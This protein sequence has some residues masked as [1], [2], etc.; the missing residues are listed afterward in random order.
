[1]TPRTRSVGGGLMML[2]II[3]V[4]IGL[5][6]CMEVPIGNP[7]RSRIDPELSGLWTLQDSEGDM[8]GIVLLEPYDK[9]TWLGIMVEPY[10]DAS[11]ASADAEIDTY[12]GLVAASKDPSSGLSAVSADQVGLYKIWLTKLGGALFMV[13]Q[14]K[15]VY[16]EGEFGAEYALNWRITKHSESSF[17]LDMIDLNHPAFEGVDESDRKALERVIRKH[18]SDSELYDEE[19]YAFKRVDPE[20]AALLG[21][22]IYSLMA[23]E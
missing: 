22:L 2:T 17:D 13:W 1:M 11:R 8:S 19:G 16:D 6:A 18:A 9:R 15:G 5:M 23:G 21:G 14:P 4:I 3:P 12:E 7:E 10:L 20:H